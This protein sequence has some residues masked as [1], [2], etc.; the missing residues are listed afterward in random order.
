MNA[1]GPTGG[2][3][4]DGHGRRGDEVRPMVLAEAIEIE[5]ELVGQL[6]FLEQILEPIGRGLN[7]PVA[8]SAVF[9]ANE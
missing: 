3:G 7:E 2:G 9:S 6:D 5:A 8:V 4:Q 1:L